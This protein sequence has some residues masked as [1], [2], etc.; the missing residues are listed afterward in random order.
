LPE[1]APEMLMSRRACFAL[2]RLDAILMVQYVRATAKSAVA[3]IASRLGDAGTESR[4]CLAASAC[5]RAS[6]TV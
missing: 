1:H 2:A 3:V 5:H 4:A 6:S